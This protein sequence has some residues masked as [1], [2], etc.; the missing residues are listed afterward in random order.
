L[1]KRFALALAITTRLF[2]AEFDGWTP[3]RRGDPGQAHPRGSMSLVNVA[4]PFS[5]TEAEKRDLIEFLR[6]LTDEE[7]LHDPRRSDPH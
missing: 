4:M 1:L 2:C 3:P 5:V 6:S 7:L